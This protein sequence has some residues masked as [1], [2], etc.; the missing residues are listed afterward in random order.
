MLPLV[1]ALSSVVAAAVASASSSTSTRPHL[2]YILTDNLGWGCVA[3]AGHAD[4]KIS[5]C[6]P[7][8]LTN[9]IA[10]LFV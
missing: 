9:L 10:I 8:L 3:L 2:V 1:L 6:Q 7:A 4:C 5:R